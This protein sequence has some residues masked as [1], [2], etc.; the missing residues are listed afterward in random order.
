[1]T[2][3]VK[4]LSPVAIP[5]ASGQRAAAV[6]ISVAFALFASVAG[7]EYLENSTAWLRD[8][9]DLR[10]MLE[11]GTELIGMVIL[12]HV[13]LGNLRLPAAT[14][15]LLH[16]WKGSLLFA[17]LVTAAPLAY[18]TVSFDDGRGYP[19]AWLASSCFLLAGLA[20]ARRALQASGAG[21]GRAHGALA[22]LCVLA[23]L[24]AVVHNPSDLPNRGYFVLAAVLVA[25][26]AL[27]AATVPRGRRIHYIGL[28]VVSL[29]LVATCWD[30]VPL[31]VAYTVLP[32]IAALVLYCHTE[33]G[34]LEPASVASRAAA[35]VAL[36]NT[37][38]Q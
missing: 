28:I 10:A 15:E 19:S 18:F 13:G 27:F 1:M 26:G 35:A 32:V 14:L 23:S 12:L 34:H 38:A 3:Q 24:N 9:D 20:V 2:C 8:R 33:I 4:K 29:V 22:M 37:P 7:H 5:L 16:A 30:G 6:S 31:V 17:V 25:M 36:Q 11:E 21:L